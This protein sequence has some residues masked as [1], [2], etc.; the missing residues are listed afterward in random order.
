M[1]LLLRAVQ[2]VELGHAQPLLELHLVACH[3]R[4]RR[5]AKEARNIGLS[6]QNGGR[7]GVIR[8]GFR[9]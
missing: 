9:R 6:W 5:S 3:H 8:M 7:I 2:P 4:L 1:A